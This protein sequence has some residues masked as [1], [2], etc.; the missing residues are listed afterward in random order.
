MARRIDKSSDTVKKYEGFVPPR[1]EGLAPY[2]I[3][4]SRD[5][6]KDLAELFLRAMI[7]DLPEVYEVFNPHEELSVKGTGQRVLVPRSLLSIIDFIIDV[8]SQTL[9]PEMETLKSSLRILASR[10]AATKKA[11]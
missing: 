9:D 4:A 11:C 5:G 6:H 1:G 7:E 2:V 8:Y 10:H 3:L